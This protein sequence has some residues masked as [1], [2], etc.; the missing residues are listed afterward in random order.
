MVGAFGT[1]GAVHGRATAEAGPR[2]AGAAQRP[3]APEP[4]TAAWAPRIGLLLAWAMAT[5]G[6]AVELGDVGGP[7][8]WVD[9][10]LLNARVDAEGRSAIGYIRF[11]GGDETLLCTATLIRPRVVLTAAHCVKFQ[12]SEVE[13]SHGDFVVQRNGAEHTFIFDRFV[14]FAPE[15]GERDGALLHLSDPVPTGLAVPMGLADGMPPRDSLVTQYGFGCTDRVEQNGTWVRRSVSYRWNAAAQRDFNC[16]GDSGGP[17]VVE[18]AGKIYEV[19]SYYNTYID[20]EGEVTDY[21]GGDH[22]AVIPAIRG[23][24][25][26]KIQAWAALDS[27]R[28][29]IP[30]GECTPNER[31]DCYTGP[32]STNGVGACHQGQETCSAAGEWGVCRDE[33][34]PMSVEICGSHNGVDEDCDGDVDE[35]CPP[36]PDMTV[37]CTTLSTWSECNANASRCDW[38]RCGC[39]PDGTSESAVCPAEPPPAEP[40]PAEPPPAEPPPAEPPPAEPPPPAMPPGVRTVPACTAYAAGDNGATAP[41]AAENTWR[42]ACSDQFRVPSGD[43]NVNGVTMRPS[44]GASGAPR[45]IAQVFR[46]GQWLTYTTW[47]HDCGRCSGDYTDGCGTAY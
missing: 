14:S 29:P 19:A 6:C 21:Y 46:S 18:P 8:G 10:D 15:A 24:I 36:P 17:V 43:V 16:P 35:S 22:N 9:E 5:T 27:A 20:R 38:L 39:H 34:R 32:A 25:E 31:R 3:A 30:V 33:V 2:A 4:K 42:C 37:D 23:A 41:V 7:N 11:Y 26:S 40:P 28:E 45:A 12:S 13:R 1:T 47:P 44:A